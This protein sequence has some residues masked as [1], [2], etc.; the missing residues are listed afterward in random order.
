MKLI[1]R[2]DIDNLGRL[3]DIVEV[4]P[5][6]GRNY[7]LPQG[8]AMVATEANIKVFEL[9]RK[10]LQEKMDKIRFEAEELA[11]KLVESR[12]VL[13][14]R[15][16][17][18]DKL[19]GSVSNANIVEALAEMGLDVDRKKVILEEAIRS[20]GEYAV[21]VKLHPDVRCELSVAVVRHDW[22]EGQPITSEEAEE[23]AS[24]ENTETVA[25]APVEAAEEEVS[26]DAGQVSEAEQA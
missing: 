4:K 8:L 25:E 3:G 23:V 1:L 16:G 20:L 21:P 26:D 10:K 19:Y 5:G 12:V 24:E 6:F 14:V 9:E 22:V 17:E 7:L 2:A 18:G 11:K 15:V 13:R